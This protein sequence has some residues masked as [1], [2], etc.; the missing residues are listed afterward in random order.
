MVDI[1]IS[2]AAT[3][4]AWRNMRIKLLK[5]FRGK[6]TQE[7]FYLSGTEIELPEEAANRLLDLGFA[8]KVEV[9]QEKL[10]KGKDAR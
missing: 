10:K 2:W 9:K 5:D 1:G 4:T 6:E 8:E 3:N 7:Q